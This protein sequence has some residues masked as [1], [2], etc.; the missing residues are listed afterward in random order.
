MNRKWELAEAIFNNDRITAPVLPLG[1]TIWF[2][3]ATDNR[4]LQTSS[5]VMFIDSKLKE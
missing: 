5:E 3:S 2:I 4:G 1:T